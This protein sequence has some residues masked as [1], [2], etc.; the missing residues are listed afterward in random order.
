[1]HKVLIIDDDKLI[2]RLCSLILRKNNVEYELSSSPAD[3]IEQKPLKNISHVFMDI[4]MPDINGIELCKKLRPKYPAYVKF[5]ALTAHV[6]PEEKRTLLDAGFDDVL[7]KPFH[8]IDLLEKLNANSI[9]EDYSP[10]DLS[11]LRKMTMD[12]EELF[13]SIVNQF[14]EET[15]SDLIKMKEEI[16]DENALLLRETVHKLAGRFA[17]VGMTEIAKKIRLVEQKL[18]DGQGVSILSREIST[19]ASQID[20]T[21]TEIKLTTLHHLN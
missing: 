15:M 6:L 2:L 3:L 10:P 13:T 4:R 12:D 11:N 20:K 16:S 8:E 19:I 9:Q 21:V 18:V 7:T 14:I 5:I 1:V 17:Q